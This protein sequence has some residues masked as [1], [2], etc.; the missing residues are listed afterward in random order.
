MPP[1][2]API[3]DNAGNGT[4]ATFTTHIDDVLIVTP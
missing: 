3:L 2:P 1:T 4:P